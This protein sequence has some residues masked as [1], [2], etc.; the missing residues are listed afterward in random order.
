MLRNYVISSRKSEVVRVLNHPST[1]GKE[2][3][4]KLS[5]A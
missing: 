1:D 3:R 2:Y 4:P 5:T